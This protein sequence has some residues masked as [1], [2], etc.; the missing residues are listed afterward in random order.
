MRPSVVLPWSMS[1]VDCYLLFCAFAI[2]GRNSSLRHSVQRDGGRT[3]R[4]LSA[5][6]VYQIYQVDRD[7][8]DLEVALVN[9]ETGSGCY[10]D[11]RTTSV[12]RGILEGGRDEQ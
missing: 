3:D 5:L 11:S 9:V 10:W 8:G 4:N 2:E 7:A 1:I 12:H 6:D